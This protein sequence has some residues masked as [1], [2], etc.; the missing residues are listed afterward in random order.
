MSIVVPARGAEPRPQRESGAEQQRPQ[1]DRD[2]QMGEAG[3]Q[4]PG[5]GRELYPLSEF[6][7]F[8]EVD[9]KKQLH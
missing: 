2:T 5:R 1:G 7:S 3:C 9:L 6:T 4:V 8:E